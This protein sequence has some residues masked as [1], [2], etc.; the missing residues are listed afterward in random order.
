M[1]SLRSQGSLYIIMI[2]DS[3]GGILPSKYWALTTCMFYLMRCIEVMC[4]CVLNSSPHY[5]VCV[6]P[7]PRLS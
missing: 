7:V 6:P 5:A 3:I 1:E 2:D 4:I